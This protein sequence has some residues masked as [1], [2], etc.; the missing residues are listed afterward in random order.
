MK[1]LIFSLLVV[2]LFFVMVTASRADVNVGIGSEWKYSSTNIVLSG[3][4]QVGSLGWDSMRLRELSRMYAI[5][6]GYQNFGAGVMLGGTSIS[7]LHEEGDNGLATHAGQNLQYGFFGHAVAPVGVYG[8]VGSLQGQY[9]RGGYRTANGNLD[10]QVGIEFG[11]F[12]GDLQLRFTVGPVT[13]GTNTTL[14]TGT[15]Q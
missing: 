9:S 14:P 10:Q 7:S 12:Q 6:V 8:I 11:K 2:G 4:E 13:P 3:S 5:G 15:G 1:N